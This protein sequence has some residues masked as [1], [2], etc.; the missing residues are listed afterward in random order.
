MS[1]LL[2]RA[3]LYIALAI[4]PFQLAAANPALQAGDV[5]QI[6]AHRGASLER[7]ECTLA[8]VRRAIDVGA[9]AV[10]VDVRTSADGQLFILHDATLDRTTNGKGAA[11]QLTYALE[12]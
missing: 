6:I 2:H 7:P 1:T 9:T 10:E 4:V 12:I 8:A 11:N 3:W 5:K